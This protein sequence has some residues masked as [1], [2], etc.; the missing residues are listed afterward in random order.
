MKNYLFLLISVVITP[1]QTNAA[2]LDCRSDI[3]KCTDYGYQYTSC[4]GNYMACPFDKTFLQCDQEAYS[5]DFKFT[6]DA[7]ISDKN[8]GWS[9]STP[10]NTDSVNGDY[11][12]VGTS[13]SSTPILCSYGAQQHASDT[14]I[15]YHRH[16][17]TEITNVPLLEY[18]HLVSGTN[19]TGTLC[20]DSTEV[21]YDGMS[22]NDPTN[23]KSVLA[24][25][26]AKGCF[27]KYTM[28][29]KNSSDQAK[30]LAST[31]PTCDDLG[32]KDSVLDCPGD[33]VV[34]P[35]DNAKVMCDMQAQAGEIKFS[36]QTA[37]HDG[38]LLCDGRNLTGSGYENSELGKILT[39]KGKTT[40][41]NG[42]ALFLKIT[43]GDTLVVSGSSIGQHSHRGGYDAVYRSVKSCG[44]T[45]NITYNSDLSYSVCGES[46]YS[47]DSYID[48]S[49]DTTEHV[50]VYAPGDFEITN[51][52][53]PKNMAANMFIYTGKL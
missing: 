7:C 28:S 1:W 13:G 16:S 5:N 21:T 8:G 33:Y 39:E 38:W 53:R 37:D 51:E 46:L 26:T 19:I 31:K 9:T 30:T 34:C 4:P 18:T 10:L 3:P 52:L 15:L 23:L 49:S 25:I 36:L 14:G 42:Q 6:A 50:Y 32:Y 40:I 27:Y 24:N 43:T 45:G 17:T 11:Y 2:E 20:L 12:V 22:T 44:S 47:S 35:F 41:P 29:T 48:S